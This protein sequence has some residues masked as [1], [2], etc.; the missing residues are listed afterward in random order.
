MVKPL[1]VVRPRDTAQ[2]ATPNSPGCNGALQQTGEILRELARQTGRSAHDI[3]DRVAAIQA[4][5]EGAVG[6][7]TRITELIRSVADTQTSVAGAVEQ[8]AATAAEMNR[9][10]KEA[11]SGVV[12]ISSNIVGVAQ[13]ARSTSSGI[14]DNQRAA[15]GLA[16]T[17]SEL[18]GLVSRFTV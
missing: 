12:Q 14:I 3:R 16:E 15:Q 5:S 18:A 11:A 4:D 2:I 8:Q 13:A 7:I 17:S 6:G 9:G 10:I 1:A